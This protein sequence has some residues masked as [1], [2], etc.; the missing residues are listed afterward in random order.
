MN[1]AD[2]DNQYV[3]RRKV[4][5]ILGASFK[6][7]DLTG[8]LCFFVNQKA[9]KLR[10]DIRV[11]T[12]ESKSEEVFL[13]KA[14]NIVDIS[15]SYDIFDSKTNEKLGAL[16][17]RGVKSMIKDEWIVFNSSD[18]EI[19]RIKE[20]SMLLAILRRF[21]TALI[22]QTFELLVGETKAV[23]FSQKFNPFVQKI[24]ISFN[25]D[26]SVAFDKRIGLCAA[27]LLS[28]IEGRQN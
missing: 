19:G 18:E 27:I 21:V 6:I 17:R 24:V 9:F 23:T 28:A 22:P 26:D 25:E 16:K 1:N 10:E 15:S 7:F 5:K 14:R 11:Y 8:N 4:F 3:I 12:D 13:I 20:D 2:Y